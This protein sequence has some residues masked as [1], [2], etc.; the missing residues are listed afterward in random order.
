MPFSRLILYVRG[1]CRL[2]TSLSLP[3]NITTFVPLSYSTRLCPIRPLGPC[4]LPHSACHSGSVTPWLVHCCQ[5]WLLPHS[6]TISSSLM[7]LSSQAHK[8]S[9]VRI[10]VQ[11]EQVQYETS[12]NFCVCATRTDKVEERCL[13][14]KIRPQP[15]L[16]SILFATSAHYGSFWSMWAVARMRLSL[17]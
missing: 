14:G 2:V 7:L 1:M 4:A 11:F 10:P 5:A 16:Q 13:L 6:R 8:P 9:A 12:L 3:P 17:L 15:S